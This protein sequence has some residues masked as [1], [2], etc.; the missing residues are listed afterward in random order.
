MSQSNQEQKEAVGY[1]RVSDE[2]QAKKE[3][4]IPAQ[5]REIDSW[6]K[7]EGY[8]IKKW[9]TDEGKTA[10]KDPQKRKG[11][12]NMLAYVRKNKGHAILVWKLNRFSRNNELS[13]VTKKFLRR[14]CQTNV[15]SITEPID[16][17][18]PA[19]RL[20][21]GLLDLLSEFWSD[22]LSED[23]KRGQRETLEQGYRP[24]GRTPYG[25]RVIRHENGKRSLEPDTITAT[26][27]EQIFQWAYAGDGNLKI[28]AR[29]N[30]EE[31][32]PLTKRSWSRNT[33]DWIL[34]NP[35]YCGDL[36]WGTG[37]ERKVYCNAHKAIVSRELFEAVQSRRTKRA[38]HPSGRVSERNLLTGLIF[39]HCGHRYYHQTSKTTGYYVCS[40]KVRK[41]AEACSSLN[42][43]SEAADRLIMDALLNECLSPKRLKH[44]RQAAMEGLTARDDSKEI[45][46]L[47]KR[48]A[49][50]DKQQY[51]IVVAVAEGSIS[52]GHAKK[53]ERKLSEEKIEVTNR[54]NGLVNAVNTP[55]VNKRHWQ[56]IQRLAKGLRKNWREMPVPMRRLV[57]REFVTRI[58]VNKEGKLEIHFR[59]PDS[60]PLPPIDPRGESGNSAKPS[61][62]NKLS[63]VYRTKHIS[64]HK[65]SMITSPGIQ[66]FV[67]TTS[68]CVVAYPK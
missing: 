11:F 2:E 65:K 56:D 15:I 20:T 26:V 12:Q 4:S 51:R 41:G 3:L 5:R 28:A 13:V 22:N 60:G 53:H 1:L 43:N 68:S 33:I 16:K 9:F 29:L 27:V 61:T 30:K 38:K 66:P 17:D 37:D 64:S 48:L 57:L 47:R 45:S 59:Y 36:V 63:S 21:E 31:Y 19:G 44:V 14:T 35:I 58:E 40:E 55:S 50:I 34:K 54:L 23:V 10:R 7:R 6:A 32:F 62:T 18:T 67:Y 39:G 8:Q 49:E 46:A 25:Y 24:A 42:V 52:S